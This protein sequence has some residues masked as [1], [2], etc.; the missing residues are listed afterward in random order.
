MLGVS[1]A[2]VLVSAHTRQD[3]DPVD[4]MPH[5]P[6]SVGSDHRGDP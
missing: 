4:P 5:P 6:T 1:G 3:V 2:F